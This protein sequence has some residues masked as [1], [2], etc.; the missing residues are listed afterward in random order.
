MIGTDSYEPTLL[1]ISRLRDHSVVDILSLGGGTLEDNEFSKLDD[2]ARSKGCYIQLDKAR[3]CGDME[4]L[5]QH[6]E[7]MSDQS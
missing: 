1:V 7:E 6:F 4:S 5:E 2:M 3:E